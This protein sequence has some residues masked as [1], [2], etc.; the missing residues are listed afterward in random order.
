[1]RELMCNL[2]LTI[3]L[4]K[5]CF[6]RQLSPGI[7]SVMT[8]LPYLSTTF[9]P[10]FSPT[11]STQAGEGRQSSNATASENSQLVKA[12]SGEG[13]ACRKADDSLSRFVHDITNLL[14]LFAT[15]FM[16]SVRTVTLISSLSCTSFRRVLRSVASPP[17][18]AAST[19]SWPCGSCHRYWK[20]ERASACIVCQ[21]AANSRPVLQ[22][23]WIRCSHLLL[24]ICWSPIMFSKF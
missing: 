17:A 9:R 24:D 23:D 5:S 3:V 12:V 20:Q 6:V 15:L 7:G 14:L 22:P 11:R 4:V 10:T 1:M 21:A 16:A 13:S 8:V 2:E 18:A 19:C